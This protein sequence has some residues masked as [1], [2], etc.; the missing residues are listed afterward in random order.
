[1]RYNGRM[2]DTSTH[3]DVRL[4]MAKGAPPAAP[5]RCSYHRVRDQPAWGW[6]S[7][8]FL[9]LV[10][11]MA[12]GTTGEWYLGMLA[13]SVAGLVCWRVYLPV[14]C[15][16]DAGGLRQT[17][18]RLRRS[19]PWR[20]VDR[21]E[22]K[23]YGLLLLPHARHPLWAQLRAIPIPAGP[24]LE[25]IQRLI[26]SEAPWAASWAREDLGSA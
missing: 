2:P 5:I 21:V 20:L 24:Q 6:A 17:A 9:V 11:L 23:P 18:W 25:A 26:E 7:A 10:F 4:A 13:L 8:A 22:R 19:V 14:T 1:M 15:E 16:I 12:Y 3:S